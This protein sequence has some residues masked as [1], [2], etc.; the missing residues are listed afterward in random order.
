MTHQTSISPIAGASV[1]P[2]RQRLI[3]NTGAAI[4]IGDVVAIDP[5]VVN[6]TSLRHTSVR[7]P[8]AADAISGVSVVALEAIPN[9]GTGWFLEEGEALVKVVA[10]S[11]GAVGANL[12][13]TA[14][15][16][17]HMTN[18]AATQR[19]IAIAKTVRNGSGFAFVEFSGRH[20]FGNLA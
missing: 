12:S 2:V 9:G 3:N 19:V 11:A 7:V 10:G 4:A 18:T 16:S 6:A 14:S 20:G 1:Q 13:A 5:T 8:L 17:N 15:A